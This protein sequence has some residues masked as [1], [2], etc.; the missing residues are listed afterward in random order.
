MQFNFKQESLK[1]H[2]KGLTRIVTI[3]HGALIKLEIKWELIWSIQLKSTH[4][5]HKQVCGLEDWN[6]KSVESSTWL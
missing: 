4:Q 3:R 2:L 5:C 1:V 6:T